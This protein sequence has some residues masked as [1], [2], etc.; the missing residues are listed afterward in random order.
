M[1]DDLDSEPSEDPDASDDG[2][3]GEFLRAVAGAPAPP[4]DPV[5]LELVDSAAAA[6]SP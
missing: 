1:T 4:E 6:R 2:S 3:I 5:T